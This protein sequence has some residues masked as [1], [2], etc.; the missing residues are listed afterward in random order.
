[1]AAGTTVRITIYEIRTHNKNAEQKSGSDENGSSHMFFLYFINPVQK[2][3]GTPLLL[4]I[5]HTVDEPLLL[6]QI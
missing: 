4:F 2:R 5:S 1:M 3:A 6:L